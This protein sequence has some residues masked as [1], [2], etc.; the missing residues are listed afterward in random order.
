[1][2]S[3]NVNSEETASTSQALLNDF[4][5]LQDKLAEVKGKISNLLANGYSTPAAQQK[6]S[7]FFDEFAKGFDQVN[8]GLQGIGQYVKAVG[9]AFSQTDDQLGANL[10]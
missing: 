2:P 5:Q 10:G 4:A 1:M 3:Y 6:F 7:P 8:Q 9:D